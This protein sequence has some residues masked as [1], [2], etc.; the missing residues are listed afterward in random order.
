MSALVGHCALCLPLLWSSALVSCSFEC[1]G[2]V[3][4]SSVGFLHASPVAAVVLLLASGMTH[5][6]VAG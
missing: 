2:L 6:R 3:L 4:L 5:V 1:P